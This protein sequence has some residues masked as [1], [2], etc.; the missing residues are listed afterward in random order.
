M[1]RNILPVFIWFCLIT[2][3]AAAE[4]K[5]N[6]SVSKVPKE[7]VS[8]LSY[9]LGQE[10]GTSL[11]NLDTVVEWDWFLRGI[12][13]AFEG[14]EPLVPAAEANQLRQDLLQKVQA[15]KREERAA[16]AEKNKLEGNKFL[17]ENAKKEG[18][19]TTPSG[20]QYQILKNGTGPK[21]VLTDKVKV[22]YRGTLLDG[23][24]FDS[25]YRRGEPVIFPLTGVIKGWQEALKLM[26]T[27]STWR[28]FVPPH[29]A[30]GERGA[31]Q[32]IGPN[33]VLIFEVELLEVVKDGK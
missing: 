20:L 21:P 1:K 31:G 33:A 17:E 18:V 5:A 23:Q 28:I 10:I 4:K 7:P 26:N 27:G 8:K 29:L 13:D 19:V 22:H 32:T 6:I 14:K 24:E 9:A 30:Y 12:K 2:S 16:L 25:S 11:K 15:K 3:L